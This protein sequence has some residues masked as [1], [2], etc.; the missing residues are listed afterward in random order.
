[1]RHRRNPD[2]EVFDKRRK[3]GK[4]ERVAVPSPAATAVAPAP[5][6]VVAARDQAI[7]DALKIRPW[8]TDGLITVLPAEP[9]LTPDQRTAALSSALIRLRLKKRIVQTSEGT[10]ALT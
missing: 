9:G 10:W 2:W 1:M 3:V 8:S 5:A 7:L 6:D 4:S